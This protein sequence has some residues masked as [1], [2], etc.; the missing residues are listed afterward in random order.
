MEFK[1]IIYSSDVDLS[2]PNGPGINEREFVESV[3]RIFTE[4]FI[5]LI[6]HFQKDTVELNLKFNKKKRS[7]LFLP[8]R[9]VN[10]I[11]FLVK[12]IKTFI[13]LKSLYDKEE[14]KKQTIF[15]FRAILFPFAYMLFVKI[16]KPQYA[17]RICGD[18]TF[19]F[20]D[21]NKLFK[22][23]KPVNKYIMSVLYKNAL[24]CDSVTDTHIKSI[25]DRF[26][27]NFFKVDN[28]VNTERFKPMPKNIDLLD[29]LGFSADDFIIGY[30]GNF[31]H[32]RGG[33]EI[34]E[35]FNFLKKNNKLKFKA[36][37]AGSDGGVDILNEKILKYKLEKDIKLTGK[38]DFSKMPLL[39]SQLDIG[40]SFLDKQYRGASEQK[41]RQYLACGVPAIVSPG[42]SEFVEE[43]NIGKV[44]EHL[45][46]IEKVAYEFLKY[47]ELDAKSKQL[48]K[49]K[50]REYAENFMSVD[51]QN[52]LRFSVWK[53][54][55]KQK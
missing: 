17:L 38:V 37:I 34:V 39:V 29:D 19:P 21:K 50:A 52:L 55:L 36:I 35:A 20:L 2:L 43:N 4:R 16:Y 12:Q 7:L 14:N 23:L 40:V 42:G 54:K 9:S 47:Y 10:P 30:T 51:S 22:L 3:D 15:V 5:I 1:K 31:P 48:I 32:I 18:G 24:G 27:G 13:A 25:A 28:G 41:V 11:R 45:N 53:E 26:N 8:K 33:D 6:P 49:E 44:V 46:G